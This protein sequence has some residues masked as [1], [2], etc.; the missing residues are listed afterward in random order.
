[1]TLITKENVP[2]VITFKGSASKFKIGFIIF[3]KSVSTN[4][5][6]MQVARPPET[7]MPEIIW[8]IKKIENALK[9]VLRSNV[10]IFT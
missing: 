10:F 5:A 7:F 8:D 6:I 1:M 4:P 2:S 3:I 9:R